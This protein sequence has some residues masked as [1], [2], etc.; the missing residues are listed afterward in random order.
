MERVLIQ[1]PAWVEAQRHVL[2]INA[3]ANQLFD[4]P[5]YNPALEKRMEFSDPARAV[6]RDTNMLDLRT[7][8][9]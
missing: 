3:L 9:P 5:L 4:Q 6:L 1:K 2:H 8:K 7:I